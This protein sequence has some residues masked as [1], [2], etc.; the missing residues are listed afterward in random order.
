MRSNIEGMWVR[1]AGDPSQNPW[2]GKVVAAEPSPSGQVF[3]L[4]VLTEE[5][6]SDGGQRLECIS[7]A[8]VV[9]AAE[10]PRPGPKAVRDDKK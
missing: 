3:Y 10:D 1:H 7:S 8:G 5:R 4:L 2:I 6:G 9:V